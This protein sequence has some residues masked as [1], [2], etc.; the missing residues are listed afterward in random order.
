MATRFEILI[1]GEDEVSIRAAGEEALEEVERLDAQLS[2][3]NPA[4][5][6]SQI[7][8][9]AA[10]A[11]VRVEPRLFRLL[12]L[13]R[14]LTSAT[15]GA[16]DITVAPLMA[17]WGFVRGTGK[18]PDPVQLSAARERIGMHRVEFD[19]AGGTIRFTTQGMRLDLGSIGKGYALE[20]AAEILREAGVTRALLHGGTS[21][22]LAMGS[23]PGE[24]AWKVAIPHPDFARQTIALGATQHVAADAANFLAVVEL[25]DE[26]L[27]V[28]AVWGKA[29]EADGRV[30]GHVLDP[31]TGEPVMGAT[32]GAMI[33]TSAMESDA[34]STALLTLGADGIEVVAH[35]RPASRLLVV[36][37]GGSHGGIRVRGMRL[38]DSAGIAT[39]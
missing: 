24:P 34:L 2:L 13:A 22:V 17:C 7:N 19:E 32:L 15:Q 25:C 31:R 36:P 5:E 38:S 4:S 21:T 33:T 29:F 37:A 9:R 28:S 14:E 30:F 18:L 11:P 10:T 35:Y 8:A 16:F 39:G 26:A 6:I 27:S 1:H 3:Y 12:L 20:R 23:P